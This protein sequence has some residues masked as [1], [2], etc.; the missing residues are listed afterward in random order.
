[1][2]LSSRVFE[3]NQQGENVDQVS[4]LAMAPCFSQAS[5]SESSIIAS[6][7]DEDKGSRKLLRRRPKVGPKVRPSATSN[8]LSDVAISTLFVKVT[9][10]DVQ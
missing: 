3:I 1:M 10:S 2:D 6:D 5:S 7:G 4:G 8:V 9:V